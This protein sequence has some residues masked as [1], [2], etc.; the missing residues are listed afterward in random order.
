MHDCR[1]NRPPAPSPH[2]R[3]KATRRPP[4]AKQTANDSDKKPK[5]KPHD[6]NKM[7]RRRRKTSNYRWVM[8]LLAIAAAL[9]FN[10]HYKIVPRDDHQQQPTELP[11]DDEQSHDLTTKATDGEQRQTPE[12]TNANKRL[13]PNRLEIPAP[14]TNT[15]E[16]MLQRRAYTT[17]YNRQTRL[18]NWVAWRL[19]AD[20][21]QGDVKRQRNAFHEDDEVPQPRATLADYKGSQW[22]RGH[23]C[24]AGDNKWDRQ[25]MYESFLL[26]NMCPQD[27]SVN[28]GDWND[29]E[30]K[31]RKWARKYGE[32]FIVCG[33]VIDPHTDYPTIGQN[34]I[35]VPEAFFKVVLVG[36]KHPKAVGFL[37]SNSKGHKDDNKRE[38]TV[39]EIERI[40]GID[41]FAA[42]PDDV[43]NSVESTVGDL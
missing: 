38:R 43:E 11:A 31:C 19:T 13:D 4:T 37:C 21:A 36:G 40:T 26:T 27:Q 9:F 25:A 17:S 23:M 20:H 42:L 22:S 29:V 32:I 35:T 14:M 30:M 10:R 12:N 18:P 41:F 6:D 16:Q 2:S 28:S 24:P 1:H 39:D 5:K 15:E 3:G 7:T 8:A 34:R 33:P